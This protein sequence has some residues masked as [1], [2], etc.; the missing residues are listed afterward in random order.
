MSS[1]PPRFAW[2]QICP[3]YNPYFNDSCPYGN[4]CQR[5]HYNW[6]QYVDYCGNFNEMNKPNERENESYKHCKRLFKN[7]EYKDC[8]TILRD[9]L[10]QYPFNPAYHSFIAKCYDK[11]KMEH[12]SYFHH[13]KI[14]AISPTNPV[15]HLYYALLLYRSK[16]HS[17]QNAKFHFMTALQLSINTKNPY[18][19]ANIHAGVAKFLY[20]TEGDIETA[21]YHYQMA[22]KYGAHPGTHHYYARLLHKTGDL[23]QAEY[24]Y[25]KSIRTSSDANCKISTWNN[26][27]YG[28]FL[29]QCERY[30]QA[31]E[32]FIICLKWQPKL[33]EVLYEYGVMLCENMKKYD[34]GLNYLQRVCEL[35][36]D[37]G[38]YIKTYSY[39]KRV[40]NGDVNDSND[41]FIKIV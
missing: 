38:Q 17:N 34:L 22:L 11:L 18:Y 25:K 41:K 9:L 21:K 16:L 12:A 13:R 14:I 19:R 3:H 4:Q 8:V 26:F 33:H 24:H 28:L 1:V 7:N 15:Y 2:K 27:Y 39:Y 20:E 10:T 36:C 35:Q 40:V 29:K 32:Q 30:E 37:C 6:Q 23:E 5:V 31:E